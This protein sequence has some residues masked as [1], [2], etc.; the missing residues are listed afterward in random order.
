MLE[1]TVVV[2]NNAFPLPST[3]FSSNRL[4]RIRSQLRSLFAM[5]RSITATPNNNNN[6]D[7]SI[8]NYSISNQYDVY[9][10]QSPSNT[11]QPTVVSSR[12]Y[13][14]SDF[15]QPRELPPPYIEE[16]SVLSHPTINS[17]STAVTNSRRSSSAGSD[18]ESTNSS[19]TISSLYRIRKRQMPTNTLRDRMRQLIAN[20]AV[21][22][23]TDD[24]NSS[25]QPVATTLEINFEEQPSVVSIRNDEQECSD[26]D[27]MLTT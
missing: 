12:S 1:P 7:N 13:L 22:V 25:I 16:Q 23:T 8:L 4:H 18:M 26:D 9:E 15:I 10:H 2:P 27:K 6:N 20:S 11:A 24:S 21:R 17:I 19:T 5:N 3:S 14:H